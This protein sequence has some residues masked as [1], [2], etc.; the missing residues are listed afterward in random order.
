MAKHAIAMNSDGISVAVKGKEEKEVCNIQYKS[1]GDAVLQIGNEYSLKAEKTIAFV[2]GDITVKVTTDEVLIQK[3]STSISL[4]DKD[5]KLAV[6]SSVIEVKDG[7]ITLN[8]DKVSITGSS[9]LSLKSTSSASL[10]GGSVAVK[11]TQAASVQGMTV[12]IKG[13]TSTTVK[14]LTTSVG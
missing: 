11:A 1:A 13:T 8:A 14:G 2:V 10:Q 6:G 9:S 5:I 12:D 3:S 4:K 7:E